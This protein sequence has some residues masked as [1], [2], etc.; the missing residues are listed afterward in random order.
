MF[1]F[2]DYELADH[3]HNLLFWSIPAKKCFEV[4]MDLND[5]A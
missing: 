1:E 2:S 4:E 3:S 5:L